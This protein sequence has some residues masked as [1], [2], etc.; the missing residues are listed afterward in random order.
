MESFFI[1]LGIAY[2]AFEGG[3]L[4][5]SL[6]SV[7]GEIDAVVRIALLQMVDHPEALVVMLKSSA[8]AQKLSVQ[9]AEGLFSPHDFIKKLLACM[10]EWG[11]PQVVPQGDGFGE[12]FVK[13]KGTGYGAAYLADLDGVGEAGAVVVVVVREIN[14]GFVLKPAEGQR[15]DDAITVVLEFGAVVKPP[16]LFGCR[17]QPLG[18]VTLQSVGG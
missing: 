11:M 15:V 6:A 16:P 5:Y 9:D 8:F 4:Q 13:Q 3:V 7:V 17:Q 14:L 10:P 12:V 2:V 1:E 18:G